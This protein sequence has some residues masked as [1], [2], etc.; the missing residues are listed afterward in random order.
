MAID[1]MGPNANEAVERGRR[2]MDQTMDKGRD[3]MDKGR[4]ML[5]EGYDTVQQVAGKGR[6]ALQGGVEAVQK[7]ASETTMDDV[8]EFVRNEPWAAMAVAFG[9]GYLVAQIFKRVA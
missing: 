4:D 3:M 5:G 7:F 1:N 2:M 8:R 6:D 9:V